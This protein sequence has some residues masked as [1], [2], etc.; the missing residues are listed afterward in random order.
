MESE[1]KDS[2]E[3]EEKEIKEKNSDKK[4]TLVDKIK[5]NPWKTSTVVLGIILL[6]FLFS[7]FSGLTGSTVTGS[8]VSEETAG[9]ALLNFANQQGAN[10]ELAGVEDA[11]DFYEVTLM[12]QGTDVPLMVTKDGKYFL[13]GDLVPLAISENTQQ[14]IEPDWSVFENELPDNIKS[15]IISFD[16]EESEVFDEE[17]RISEFENYDLISKTLIVFYHPGCGWCTEY[18]PVLVEAQGKYP[19]ITIYALV[20]SEDGDIA[21]KY[22]VT[23]TPANIINGKYFVSGYKSIE[24]LS[25]ILDKLN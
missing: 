16:S 13:S 17:L 19:E 4:Q 22:G 5:E 1:K 8:V 2:D 23:G 21:E 15:K 9:N 14:S 12:I 25:E 18:Y 7:N 6:V 24:D 11:G 3:K 20:L 10:A